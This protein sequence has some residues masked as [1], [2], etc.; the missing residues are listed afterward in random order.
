MND[1]YSTIKNRIFDIAN[2]NKGVKAIIAIGSSTR[3]E[4]KADDYSDLDL[5]IATDDTES[6]LYGSIPEQLGNVKIS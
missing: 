4:L 2:A 5:L 3:S 1:R 6:W